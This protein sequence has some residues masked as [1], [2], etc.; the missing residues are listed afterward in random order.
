MDEI[1]RTLLTLLQEDSSRSADRLGQ[2]LGLS[3][4]AVTRRIQSLKRVG[5]IAREVAVLDERFLAKRVTAIVNIQF[6]RHQPQE[7]DRF[8][9]TI[10]T[11]PEVQLFVEISG[12]MDALLMV[13]VTD[14]EHFNSFTDRLASMAIVRRYETSFIKRIVKFTTAVPL[15]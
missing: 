13:A 12:A 5:V 14:M 7:A 9:R 1:D 2:E 10:R 3:R 8:R 6:D 15:A 4:S 11:F